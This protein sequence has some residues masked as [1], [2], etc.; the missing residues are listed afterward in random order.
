MEKRI[1]YLLVSRDSRK[2][3]RRRAWSQAWPIVGGVPKMDGSRPTE[4]QM[5]GGSVEE[6]PARL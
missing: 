6:R 2:F 3:K 5:T 4:G 1:E